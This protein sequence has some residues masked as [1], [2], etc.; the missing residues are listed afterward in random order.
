MARAKTRSNP[1]GLNKQARQLGLKGPLGF[2]PKHVRTLHSLIH[3]STN[4][5][6]CSVNPLCVYPCV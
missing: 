4:S 2:D 3:T 5:F 6:I 1:L